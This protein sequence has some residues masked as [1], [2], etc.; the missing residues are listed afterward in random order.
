MLITVSLL[1]ELVVLWERS[2]QVSVDGRKLIYSLAFRQDTVRIIKVCVS[3]VDTPADDAFY[4]FRKY[5]KVKCKQV[6][7]YESKSNYKPNDRD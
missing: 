3:N 6:L 7:I 2:Y 4:V 5:W 1:S